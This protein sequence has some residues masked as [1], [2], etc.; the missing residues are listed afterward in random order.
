VDKKKVV[1]EITAYLKE[2]LAA[3]TDSEHRKELERLLLMYR[4]LPTREYGG[5]DHIIPSTLVE[6]KTGQTQAWYFIA[7]QGG[8][9]VTRVE[10]KPVQVITPHSPLGGALLGKKT[11]QSIKVQTRSGEREYEI[12][13]IA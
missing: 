12:V 8:G 13:G 2:E 6:L 10:G 5:E 9:L 4:F 11:G 7:P 1:A 3:S